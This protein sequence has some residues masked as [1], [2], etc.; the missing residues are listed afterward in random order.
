MKYIWLLR[1]H[2]FICEAYK[3]KESAVKNKEEYIQEFEKQNSHLSKW[4]ISRCHGYEIV[5][6][7]L[8]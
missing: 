2:S 1:Q 5:R 3:T 4:Q 7:K 6:V 8:K